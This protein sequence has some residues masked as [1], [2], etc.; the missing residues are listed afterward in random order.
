V[1][2]LDCIQLY[3][4]QLHHLFWSSVVT[5]SFFASQCLKMRM[6]QLLR[7]WNLCEWIGLCYE[8]KLQHDHNLAMFWNHLCVFIMKKIDV[9]FLALA[10]PV[11][12][13]HQFQCGWFVGVLS[14]FSDNFYSLMSRGCKCYYLGEKLKQHALPF[15]HHLSFAG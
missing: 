9:N 7:R 13:W 2:T 15:V 11:N 6:L 10:M 5:S 4:A 14:E 1:S 3:I 8:F 12:M